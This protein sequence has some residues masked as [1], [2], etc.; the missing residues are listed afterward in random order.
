MGFNS[1]KV[2]FRRS[3]IMPFLEYLRNIEI[4][5]DTGLFF[6]AFYFFFRGILDIKDVL[7]GYRIHSQNTSDRDQNNDL[8]YDKLDGIIRYAM[9]TESFYRYSRSNL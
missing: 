8:N 1:N 2:S 6:V 3:A 9:I 5:L 4:N 7:T